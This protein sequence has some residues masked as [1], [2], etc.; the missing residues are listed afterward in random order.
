MTVL[1]G[2]QATGK[3]TIAKVLA[4][5]RY[6]S[7]IVNYSISL[8][9]QS[10]FWVNF[11]FFNGLREWEIDSYLNED[12]EFFYEN[13]LYIFELNCQLLVKYDIIKG[14]EVI[15]KEMQCLTKIESTSIEFTDLLFQL[16]E[17]RNVEFEQNK[18]KLNQYKPTKW[19][20]NENFYRLNVKKIMDNPLYIPTE[21]NS[22][23]SNLQISKA[24]QDEVNKI[25]KI[26]KSYNRETQIEPLSIIYKNQDGIGYAKKENNNNFHTTQNG[27]SG[28]Q[29]TIPIVLSIKYY[30]ELEGRER[31]FIIEEPELNLFPKAQK[32]LM[33]FFVENINKNGHSFLLP[34]HSPYMVSALNNLMVAY[35]IGQKHKEK[36][37]QIIPEQYWIN[38]ENVS[39][40]KLVY[41]ENEQGVVA[42]K[43]KGNLI[44]DDLQEISIDYLD[45]ISTEI[46][47]I[48]DKLLQV[49]DEN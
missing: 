40:Y 44:L 41:D 46:N 19:S 39:A 42:N 29:S 31:T 47:S 27:A 8:E 9:K 35:R 48:W 45:G 21:R 24:L 2:E 33:A 16:G 15:E 14:K 36:V 18:K 28:Y 6:F 26:L 30:N 7:Y 20:P 25:I 3:S 5:C 32:K 13:E 22:L 37:S 17:L 38:P 10:E 43:E 4:V 34:T 11:Q 1:I 23:S 12:S 49:E